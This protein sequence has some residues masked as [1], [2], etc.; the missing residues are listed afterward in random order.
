MSGYVL[1]RILQTFLLV[2]G[3]SFACYGLLG[4]MPGD[5]LDIACQSNPYCT[6]TNLQKMKETLGLDQPLI[7]RYGKWLYG[8]MQGDLGYSRTYQRPVT[9][10]LGPRLVNSLILSG[11]S[12]LLSLFIAIP[13]GVIVSLKAN[14][15]LDYSINFLAFLGISVPSFWLALIL[16]LVFSVHWQWFPAGGTMSIGID[17]SQLSTLLDRATYLVLPVISL[18]A[19]TI[20]NWV[21]FTR[22][23]MIEV[24][25]LDFMRTARAK[26]LSRTRIVLRHGLRNALI[27]LITVVAVG[28]SGI[29]S[30]AVITETVFA[31]QG[32]G[33]LIFDSIFANDYNVA[34]CSFVI[35]ILSV[36]LMNLIADIAYAY[37]DPRI[38]YT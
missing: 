6:P 4:L 18:S 17:G 28:F 16:I 15:K 1:R 34:M 25:Q 2:I 21:R 22:S 35:T 23:K 29:F 31:Y 20:A 38:T 5:P 36:L 32:V 27:P 14:S 33:K 9:E 19:M 7:V 12:L 8:F 26:G 13:I 11:A 10:I 37:A 24:L 30:G 3:L